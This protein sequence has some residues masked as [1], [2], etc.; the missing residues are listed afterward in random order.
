MVPGAIIMAVFSPV[1]GKIYDKSGPR[2][3]SIFGL[4]LFT[5]T[6]IGFAVMNL[7]TG[8]PYV[9]A[10]YTIWMFSMALLIMPLTT[11]GLNTLPPELM[12][13]GTA[14]YNTI[15]TIAGAL[16][17]AILVRVMT[18]VA[19]GAVDPTSADASMNGVRW[20]FIVA[21]A[22]AIFSFILGIVFVKVKTKEA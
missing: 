2:K 1:A 20:A 5:A 10:M 18:V 22:T 15:K 9:C 13:H 4:A 17:T 7:Q 16:G 14:L 19:S 6:I 3:L 11:W 21:S 12:A 8:F